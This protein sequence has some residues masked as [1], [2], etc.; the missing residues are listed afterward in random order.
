MQP[1]YPNRQVTISPINLSHGADRVGWESK[2]RTKIDPTNNNHERG[3]GFIP[4]LFEEMLLLLYS[5]R[6]D[7]VLPRVVI[8]EFECH[9]WWLLW[10]DLAFTPHCR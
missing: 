2:H 5:A 8:T 6:S 1:F 10:L 7:P 3:Q 4:G 9:D